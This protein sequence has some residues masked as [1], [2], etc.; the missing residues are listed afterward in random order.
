MDRLEKFRRAVDGFNDL[1]GRTT[2]WL[3]IAMVLIQFTV[4][5]LRYVFGFGSIMMQESVVYLHGALFMLGAAYTLLSEGHV[6]VDIFY[7]DA[8]H[9][10]KALVDMFGVLFLLLPICGLI[11]L[12]SWSYVGQSWAILE[13]SR[14]TSGIHAVYILKTAILAFAALLSLQGLS[15][16]AR[17]YLTI[18][19]HGS[20]DGD[21][22]S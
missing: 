21:A 14:E 6:R 7:R 8:T 1:V 19:G 9:K 5:M 17:A 10:K 4:V 20:T 13:G 15:M 22:P 11:W 12:S 16:A 3:V 18:K 2:A